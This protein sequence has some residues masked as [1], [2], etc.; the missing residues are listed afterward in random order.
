MKKAIQIISI[1]L[2]ICSCASEIKLFKVDDSKIGVTYKSS[3]GTVFNKSYHFSDFFV[4]DVDSSTLWTPKKEDIKL[5][6]DIL[7]STIKAINKSKVNQMGSCPVIHRNLNSYFRQYVG[8]VNDK[9][10][11]VVHINF[12]WNKYGLLDRLKGFADRRLDH[13]SDYTVVF[14]G[15]SHYWQINV[16]FEEKKLSNLMING[17]A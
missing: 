3:R 12:Y 6:E 7:R 10:Q 13:D 17:I 14:D 9:G 1:S 2:I 8:I 5:A 16:N 11:R 4:S 15:C